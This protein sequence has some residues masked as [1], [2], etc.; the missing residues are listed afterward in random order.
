MAGGGLVGVG[1]RMEIPLFLLNSTLSLKDA[2]E[3]KR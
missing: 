1:G 3:P 2:V